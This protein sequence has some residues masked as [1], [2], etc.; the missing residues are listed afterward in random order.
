MKYILGVL[1][2]IMCVACY[3]FP[4]LI[5]KEATMRIYGTIFL[6]LAILHFNKKDDK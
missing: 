1:C 4:D 3:F 5:D 2:L 6:Q